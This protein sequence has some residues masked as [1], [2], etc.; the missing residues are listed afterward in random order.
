VRRTERTESADAALAVGAAAAAGGAGAL[1]GVSELATAG[2]IATMDMLSSA[3]ARPRARRFFCLKTR[4]LLRVSAYG[5]SCR[6]R[7]AAQHVHRARGDGSLLSQQA[8]VA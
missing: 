7:G 8:A 4:H 3:P 1:D 2:A 6:A 5:V